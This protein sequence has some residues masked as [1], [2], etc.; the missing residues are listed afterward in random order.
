MDPLAQ[1]KDIHLPEPIHNYPLAYGWWVMLL[2]IMVI[3]IWLI[4]KFLA[5]KKLTKAKKHAIKQLT[6]LDLSS[7]EMIT[8]L[9]WSALQY[10]PRQQVANLHG[11][12]L[13]AFFA[14]CLPIK[15]RDE[16]T[17][18]IAPSLANQYQAQPNLDELPALKKAAILWL[19][20]ALPP[21]ENSATEPEMSTTFDS[22][23]GGKA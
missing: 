11:E 23:A 19:T 13:Q 14:Q 21:K 3:S 22:T 15:Q 5:H 16:F 20:S 2:L 4:R 6:N 10:F 12:A 18:L 1:L 8:L 17:T 7:D 9:K